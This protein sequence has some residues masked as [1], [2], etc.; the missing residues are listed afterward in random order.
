M[1]L[2]IATLAAS[3]SDWFPEATLEEGLPVLAEAGFTHLEYNDQTFPKYKDLTQPQAREVRRQAAD[4]GLTLW[5]AHSFCGESDLS[6]L[7]PEHRRASLELH[8]RCVQRLGWL[9]VRNFVVHQIEGPP[10]LLP[11]RIP[12]GLEAVRRLCEAGS[13]CGVRILVENFV[14]F[15]CA[16]VRDFAE[17]VGSDN[18]GI[19]FDV[20]HAHHT[21]RSEPE[22]IAACGAL[23]ASLHVH[24]NHGPATGDEHLLP[25]HGTTD[26]LP[27]LRALDGAGY[28]GPFL[29]EVFP[30][31][32]GSRE[33]AHAFVREAA[34]AA[35]AVLAAGASA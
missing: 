19:V 13:E 3:S 21:P 17:Q 23:L 34:G 25:G 7:D 35:R 14:Q 20:G 26:W 1:D 9:G 15:G 31:V 24:D 12:Y 4:L 30:R 5:S 2:G 22:E 18:V 11:Q 27:I 28:T 29:M 16:E 32:K 33:D 10:A 8:L 6:A